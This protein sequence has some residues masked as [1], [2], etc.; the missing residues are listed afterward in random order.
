MLTVTPS[1]YVRVNLPLSS[2][3]HHERYSNGRLDCVGNTCVVRMVVLQ[4]GQACGEQERLQGRTSPPPSTLVVGWKPRHDKSWPS[5]AL[6][7]T[8]RT[9]VKPMAVHLELS[10]GAVPDVCRGT[11]PVLFTKAER[12]IDMCKDNSESKPEKGRNRLADRLGFLLAKQWLR[13]EHERNRAVPACKD[14]P[15]N[16]KRD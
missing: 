4:M 14:S 1:F 9:P 3:S 15:V 11:R 6:G 2:P 13:L 10:T 12:T 8:V 16:A 7:Q 5:P